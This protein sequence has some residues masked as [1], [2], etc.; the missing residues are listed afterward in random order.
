M[1]VSGVKAAP[2]VLSLIAPFMYLGFSLGAALGSLTLRYSGVA[3]LGYASAASMAAALALS[4]GLNGLQ[5]K[6][7]A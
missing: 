2:I 6:E 1:G 7:L 5:P 3:N 4:S